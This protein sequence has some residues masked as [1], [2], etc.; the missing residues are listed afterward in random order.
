MLQRPRIQLNPNIQYPQQAAKPEPG[1]AM[2]GARAGQAQTAQQ[3]MAAGQQ[4]TVEHTKHQ[5]QQAQQ[6]KHQHGMRTGFRVITKV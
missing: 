1:V 4:Q 2:N 3:A 5:R 6:T